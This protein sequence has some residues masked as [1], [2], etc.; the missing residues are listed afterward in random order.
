MA[1]SFTSKSLVKESCV[2][3]VDSPVPL[4][5]PYTASVQP[6]D[7]Y[8]T[9]DSSYVTKN[10]SAIT[11]QFSVFLEDTF[12]S[13]Y[14][15]IGYEGCTATLPPSP[16]V[17][18]PQTLA[19]PS[20]ASTPSI[21]PAESSATALASVTESPSPVRHVHSIQIIIPSV[22]LP[23][24]GLMIVLLYFVDIRRYRKQRSQATS[25]NQ[26]DMTSNKQ[27]YV[28]QKAELEDEERRKHELDADGIAYE[29]EGED[30]FFEMS[31][32][33]YKETRSVSNRTQELRGMEHSTELEVP[34]SA[35]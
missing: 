16:V 9:S 17:P 27:L 13:F 28:D 34:G 35:C 12:S 24:V 32:D 26:P 22:V 18:A 29:M 7:P 4:I 14:E 31:G 8:T 20:P 6:M 33:G 1:Y 10:A 30:T 3:F 19:D 11:A 21:A 15:T 25:T 5:S 2:D 23:I